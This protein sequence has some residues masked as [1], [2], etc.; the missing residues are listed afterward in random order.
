MEHHWD[1]LEQWERRYFEREQ[2]DLGIL[3]NQWQEKWL[4]SLNQ[5]RKRQVLSLLDNCLVHLQAGLLHSRSFEETKKRVYT[6]ARIF[7]PSISSAEALRQLSIEQ[8]NYLA[9][10]LMAKQRLLSV[11]QGGVTGLGGLFFLAADLPALM[12]IQLRSLQ[13][14]AFVYGYDCHHPMEQMVM[15]KLYHLATLPKKYQKSEWD[16][17]LEESLAH[18][19]AIFYE[20]DDSIIQEE[21]L[22]RFTPQL[23][24]S[25]LITI[26]RRKTVQFVPLFGV[27]VGAGMN[28][29]LT[30]QVIEVGQHFYLKRRLLDL[31]SDRIT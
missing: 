10:Q 7:H 13:Q 5:K 17:L 14:L 20:G 29:A 27:V 23:A 24:K 28:Y 21:W 6:H 15:L 26:L 9:D 1:E 11:G 16:K 12:A 2:S 22:Q 8:A 19:Q 25:F 4:K 31:A 18:Q 30:K 3:Y